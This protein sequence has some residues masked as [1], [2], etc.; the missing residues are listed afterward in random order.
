VTS[1]AQAVID[2][3]CA[4]VDAD[5]EL[6]EAERAAARM[7]FADQEPLESAQRK[8]T[9]ARHKRDMIR[10]D[11]GKAVE[12]YRESLKVAAVR[13]GVESARTGPLVDLGS[14]AAYSD[15]CDHPQ[16]VRMGSASTTGRTSETC[17]KCGKILSELDLSAQRKEGP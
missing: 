1:E 11:E 3:A 10:F 16:H 8:I 7:E 6:H 9:E 13:E 5:Q 17:G 4:S 14:F 12:A 15:T 2:A